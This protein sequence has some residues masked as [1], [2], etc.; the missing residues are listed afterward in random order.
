M[1]Q[2][3][4]GTIPRF[5]RQEPD[6]PSDL[7]TEGTLDPEDDSTGLP[8]SSSSSVFWASPWWTSWLQESGRA[9]TPIQGRSGSQSSVHVVAYL[10]AP[11]L[12]SFFSRGKLLG[13][14]APV[15]PDG[16]G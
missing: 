13:G 9:T 1:G 7:L 8:T 15:G 14:G 10:T 5:G 3:L 16:R 2:R 11:Y 6:T 4:N 12:I